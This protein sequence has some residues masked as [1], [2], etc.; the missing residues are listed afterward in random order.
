MSSWPHGLRYI[1]RASFLFVPSSFYFAFGFFAASTRFYYTAFLGQLFILDFKAS[2][3]SSKA[4][5]LYGFQKCVFCSA[6]PLGLLFV[7]VFVFWF[8]KRFSAYSNSVSF[9][10][11]LFLFGFAT[12]R[13]QKQ[14]Y[15][16]LSKPRT[17]GCNDF[18]SFLIFLI[19]LSW[20]WSVALF[21]IL[22]IPWDIACVRPVWKV[23]ENA[24]FARVCNP[25]EFDTIHFPNFENPWSL[26]PFRFPLK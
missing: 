21:S 4:L 26:P 19:I 2:L 13:V 10:N 20:P 25:W 23:S 17:Q 11:N 3:F 9:V 5:L 6:F 22:P 12:L 1:G 16:R 18:C 7:L 24:A 15:L 8:F 14:C